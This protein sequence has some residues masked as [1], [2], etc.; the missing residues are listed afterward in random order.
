MDIMYAYL[1]PV[2]CLS[3]DFVLYYYVYLVTPNQI[4]TYI[5]LLLKAF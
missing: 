3:N 1:I 2:Y 4:N 5:I